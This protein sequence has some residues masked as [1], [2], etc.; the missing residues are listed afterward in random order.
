MIT[1]EASAIDYL[2]VFLLFTSW[3]LL[4]SVSASLL[5]VLVSPS[6]QGSGIPEVKAYLNGVNIKGF[7]T[8]KTIL[9]KTIGTTLSVASGL[10][11]GPEGPIVHLGAAIG[12]GVTRTGK[13]VSGIRRLR[14]NNPTLAALVGCSHV[15][16]AIHRSWLSRCLGYMT[17][18]RN[19]GERRDFICIGSAC[20]FAAAFGAPIGGILFAFEEVGSHFPSRMLW[21]TLIGT[22]IATFC[23]A[24]YSNDLTNYGVL[25][26]DSI[27]T[28]DGDVL[29]NRFG[30]IPYYAILGVLGGLI[31]ACFNSTWRRIAMRRSN[32]HKGKSWPW[33]VLEVAC[34]SAL[35][36]A[37]TFWLPILFS[38]FACRSPVPAGDDGGEDDDW[39]P[40]LED[41]DGGGD[42]FVD[43]FGSRFNCGVN[44]TNELASVFF[45]SREEAIKN[46][47]RD[48]Q[49][50][51]ER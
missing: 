42:E 3:N 9:I 35:T 15:D 8:L 41:D 48:P 10:A 5:T 18:F 24:V 25:T 21:R 31:G 33:K 38:Y 17:T 28:P 27:K 29:K 34:L 32:W 1:E 47:L 45:G 12:G 36:S 2:R 37:L 44:Q 49:T 23:I 16:E 43:D 51:D 39:A 20:G 40:W 19:D 30:E 13:M 50:F 7:M 4:L 14:T 26:L 11:V 22:S 46:I 6:A